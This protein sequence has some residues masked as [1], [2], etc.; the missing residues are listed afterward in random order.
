MSGIESLATEGSSSRWFATAA[1]ARKVKLYRATHA[2]HWFASLAKVMLNPYRR[3]KAGWHSHHSTSCSPLFCLRLKVGKLSKSRQGY[4][5]LSELRVLEQTYSAISVRDGSDPINDCPPSVLALLPAHPDPLIALAH[6]KLHAF[7]F[8][9]VP[10]CWRRLYTDASLAKAVALIEQGLVHS[11]DYATSPS[12]S[13]RKRR[14]D[15]DQSPDD[16]LTEEPWIDEAAKVLDM[17]AIMAGPA[18]REGMIEALLSELQSYLMRAAPSQKK[19]LRVDKGWDS[20][21]VAQNMEL[22]DVPHIQHPIQSAAAPSMQAFEM[23]MKTAQPLCIKDVLA[24]WPAMHE[25]PW[26]SPAY[27]LDKTLGGRRLIPVEI[28]RSYTDVN[29]G[30]SII[31]FREFMERYMMRQITDPGK[32]GYLAQHDLFSQIPSLRNDIAIPDYCYTDSPPL[33]TSSLTAPEKLWNRLDEPLLN[34]WFGP[35]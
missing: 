6:L 25:Q 2:D 20:F 22:S 17:A 18:G 30:Q 8:A 14:G 35:A 33:K 5:C 4:K 19:R 10:T 24:H 21:P 31:T 29:W 27:L 11:K 15:P 28:G 16:G 9:S 34:A 7:P 3:S 23:H 13:K 1:A 32:L 12:R 26:S